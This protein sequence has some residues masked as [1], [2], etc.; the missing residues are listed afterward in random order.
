M[1]QNYAQLTVGTEI[2][3]AQYYP[4][5]PDDNSQEVHHSSYLL[6]ITL[7]GISLHFY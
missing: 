3:Y 1:Q 4:G 7:S 2:P 5:M 6:S